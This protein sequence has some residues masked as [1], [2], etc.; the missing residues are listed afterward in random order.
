MASCAAIGNRRACRLPTGT[1]LAKLPE[2]RIVSSG[3][4]TSVQNLK[5]GPRL[6]PL[7]AA[8][9]WQASA[10]EPIPRFPI[11]TDSLAITRPVEAAKPFTVA[12]ERGAIFGEQCGTFE[13]WL[14]PVKILSHFTIAADLSDYPVPIDV[15]ALAST[16][17]VA[18]AMTTI[19]YSHAAFTV[20]QRMF[21]ARGDAGGAIVVVF[22]IA[23]IRPM[24]PTLRFKPEMQ[25]MWPAPNFGTPN[26]EWVEKGGYYVLHT[27]N[28][29]LSAAI[30]MPGAKPGIL[31]PYQE[32]PKTYP[33]ELTVA[34]DPKT[35][36]ELFFPLLMTLTPSPDASPALLAALHSSIP[37]LYRRNEEYYAHFFDR[38]LTSETPAPFFHRALRWAATAI[39]Q[40]K[41]SRRSKKGSG[42]SE[43]S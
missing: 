7:L 39:D 26:A 15:T 13:A 21:A 41:V 33:V 4:G 9:A 5:V 1:Q 20:K 12:G 3:H 36:S 32:R 27:D 14:Y 6:I 16:I 23:A 29:E 31:P 10:L 28:P 2:K 17:E 25:R 24:H 35:D 30:A 22:E 42:V 18:P 8:A 38:R 43:V 11:H 34:F 19:T 40:G 37:D